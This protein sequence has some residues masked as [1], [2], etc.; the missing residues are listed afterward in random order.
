MIAF[1]R[2]PWLL[3]VSVIIQVF[4]IDWLIIKALRTDFFRL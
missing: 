2:L 4:K 3:E 1:D